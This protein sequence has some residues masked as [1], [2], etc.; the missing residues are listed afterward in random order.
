MFDNKETKTNKYI[1]MSK[2][3]GQSNYYTSKGFS[4]RE[5]ADA[6]AKLMTKTEDYASNTYFL[7]EQSKDYQ[8]AELEKVEKTYE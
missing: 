2:I 8:E 3:K 7:F 1:V 4:I 6:Y 5:D